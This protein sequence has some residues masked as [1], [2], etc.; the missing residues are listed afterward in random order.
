MIKKLRNKFIA[1]S[2]L[3][4]TLVLTVIIVAINVINFVNVKNVIDTRME[5]LS[6]NGGMLP[7][8]NPFPRQEDN[9]KRE[10]HFRG[11]NAEAPFDTRFFTVELDENQ[12]VAAVDT[13]NINAITKEDAIEYTED[14]R[15]SNRREGFCQNYRYVVLSKENRN[16]LYIFLDCERELNTLKKFLRISVG[17]SVLGIILVFLLVVFFSG[18][19]IRPVA[20]S[21]EKQKRFITDASHEIKTPLTIIE[22]NTEIVEME[23]GESEWTKSI[24]KQIARLT[25]LTEKLVFLSRMDE[26]NQSY[27][28][29]IDFNLSEAVL[30]TIAPYQALAET[31]GKHLSVNV[32]E[33]M[34]FTGDENAI[35]Q[36]ISL[37]LDNAIK[38]SEEDGNI[39][40]ESKTVGKH[41]VIDVIN[42]VDYI[43]VGKHDEL[44]DRFY[45]REDSRNSE[46]G[47]FGIGL[48][49]V[50]AIVQAHK[51]R[52]AARSKDGKSL[53]IQMIL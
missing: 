3:S 30:D 22:A 4:I 6:E 23:S 53:S 36:A 26:E 41:K 52:V 11:L 38:Y 49:T 5:M 29:R 42:T 7:K 31:K 19:M 17:I 39:R 46:T 44:F 24:R 48:S 34:H 8:D 32:E 47:G 25:A 1:I 35:R 12:S 21:Y 16:T 50:Y 10:E 27:L 14:V 18:R 51:G 40:V 13:G 43:E 9:F 2:M 37:L 15:E 28:Q 45:R 33:D 20:E